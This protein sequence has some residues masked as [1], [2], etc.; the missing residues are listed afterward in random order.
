MNGIDTGYYLKETCFKQTMNVNR[1]EEEFVDP[2]AANAQGCKQVFLHML[3]LM[4]LNFPMI[5]LCNVGYGM[6]MAIQHSE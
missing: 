6:V 3:R 5:R 4:E 2:A 1:Y